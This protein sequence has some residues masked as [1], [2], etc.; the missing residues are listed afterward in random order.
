MMKG[1]LERHLGP[2]EKDIQAMLEKLGYSDLSSFIQDVVPKEILLSSQPQLPEKM[3]EAQLIKHLKSLASDN[4]VF[5][6]LLGQG[7]FDTEVPNVI[8]RNVF[9]NPAWYTS[10]TPYQAEI[11]QGRLEALFHFQTLIT[12][13]TA[14][15]V[16]NASL[17]DEAS[18]LAEAVNLT[19]Q[20][21]KAN[22]EKRKKL[23]LHPKVSPYSLDVLALRAEPFGIEI[24]QGSFESI[25]DEH[26]AV[27]LPYLGEDGELIDP[28]DA[29]EK[30]KQ[31]GC[32]VIMIADLL[33]L[34]LLK[35]PG[36]LGADIA[37]G[38]SQ[39]LGVPLGFGGP[40]AA[41]F[42]VREEFKRQIPGRVV[43]ESKDVHGNKTFRL[44][45]QVR[46]QH[47]RREKATSNICT[48]Q[49]LLAIMTA[50]Y[51]IYHGADGLIALAKK[52]HLLTSTLASLLKERGIGLLHT[53]YFDTLRLGPFP[54]GVL[55]AIKKRALKKHFNL[56]YLED[57]SIG[58]SLD[59][60]SDFE[61]LSSL[62]YVLTEEEV[63]VNELQSSSVI[64]ESLE[65]K[66]DFLKQ[67]I[68]HSIH[69]ETQMMRYIRKLEQKDISLLNS[70][71]PLG[72]CS[73]KLNSATSL[74]ALSWEEFSNIHPF[75][76][77]EQVQGYL[78]I[79]K[80]LEGYLCEITGFDSCCLQ[81]NSGAQ[82]ELAALLVLRKYFSE[83]GQ[84]QRNKALIPISAHGTNPASAALAGFDVLAVSCTESGDIDLNDL[85]VKLEEH[86]DEV[87]VFMLTYPSTHGV[88]EE[89]I[90]KLCEL[91]HSYGAQ[92]YLDGANLNAQV[93]LCSPAQMGADICHLN[94]HKTFSIPHGG[95]G[96]GVGPILC[97]KHLSPFFP[98]HRLYPKYKKGVNAPCYSP[99]GSASILLISY[100]YIRMLGGEGLKRSSEVAILNANYL[101]EVLSANY[102]VLYSSK[103][104]FVAHELILDFREFKKSCGINIEDIARRL[105]DF[106]FHAPTIS[107]PVLGTMMIE[108]T[109]S[110]SKEE[111]DRFCMALGQVREEISKIEQSI[112]SQ[113]DNPIKN[114]PHT[115]VDVS[116]WGHSYSIKEAC[117]ALDYLLEN[118]PWP[119]AN[120]V[121]H[122]WGDRNLVCACTS[123][124]SDY[125]HST[126]SSSPN[127]PG[128]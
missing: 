126:L 21:P 99:F 118:K 9:E 103:N 3:G 127:L 70:M 100:A 72:S 4:Q 86:G 8:K 33:A 117:F 36:E 14:L 40:S 31:H 10:Y 49:A 60:K 119:S 105:M 111:L 63:L 16:A 30:A 106:G 6:S 76:P 79:I 65:R 124:M 73:M 110:E 97:K 121:D 22:K 35:P 53:N 61:E 114:A 81:P 67:R 84:P 52:T 75:A 2:S 15:P 98:N 74:Q 17:L 88:F 59:E 102:K 122:V 107:W 90:P 128:T 92:V 112:F 18:A 55:K 41:F 12:E 38:S 20:H 23:Y 66:E 101:K 89:G 120:A 26:F 28:R 46:E 43:G 123:A 1:F 68:F 19:F 29:I 42:A 95:G 116:K 125:A 51:S 25:C 69:S 77:E 13:L 11:S 47:I 78:S 64:P 93:S 85:K 62:I 104:G 113:E 82:G 37:L 80:K 94:L 87:A 45:L 48:A 58:I 7:F 83:I 24:E 50:M 96:P 109:E 54:K 115:I 32:S 5:R 56:R 44:A 71:I 34:N 39:R 57:S 108:P 91:V 27:V